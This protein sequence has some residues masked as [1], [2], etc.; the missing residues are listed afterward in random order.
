MVEVVI[1]RG[2]PGAGKTPFATEKFP[3]HVLIEPSQ[4]YEQAGESADDPD[5]A[6]FA[7]LWCQKRLVEVV[8][9]GKNAVVVSAFAKRWHIQTYIDKL[10]LTPKIRVVLKK[11]EHPNPSENIKR[12]IEN[13]KQAWQDWTSEEIYD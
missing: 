13:Q 1:V 2:L 3:N 12:A 7:H 9:E 4:Y 11:G 5:Q 8:K 6:K 10:P